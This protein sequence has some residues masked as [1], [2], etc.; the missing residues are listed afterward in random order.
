MDEKELQEAL[1]SISIGM[2]YPKEFAQSF[3]PKQEASHE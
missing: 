1:R 3:F 2:L